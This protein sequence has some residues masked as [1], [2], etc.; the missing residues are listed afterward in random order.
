M[1][2]RDGTWELPTYRTNEVVKLADQIR[3]RLL[4]AQ[5]KAV[6]VSLVV[7]GVRIP[8]KGYPSEVL[9]GIL[10][11]FVGALSGV[12]DDPLQIQVTVTGGPLGQ[13]SMPS[14]RGAG[15]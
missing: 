13:H 12:L 3:G 8:L 11:G 5:P 6:S 10:R 4:D 1:T 15:A 7:D 9:S 2:D 14:V